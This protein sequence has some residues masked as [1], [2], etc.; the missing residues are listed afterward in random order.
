[1]V[2]TAYL[3][4]G[5]NHFFISFAYDKKLHFSVILR[6]FVLKNRTRPYTFT[7]NVFCFPLAKFREE[8]QTYS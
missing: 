6:S 5:K 3:F 8:V 1:M 2:L 7:L 4:C